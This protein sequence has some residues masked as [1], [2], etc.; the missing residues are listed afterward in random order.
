MNTLVKINQIDQSYGSKRITSLDLRSLQL[1]CVNYFQDHYG[2]SCSC[3]FLTSCFEFEKYPN[4]YTKILIII[5]S[6]G[7]QMTGIIEN[8]YRCVSM[9]FDARFP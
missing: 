7:K 3:W 8:M 1:F 6:V 9:K 2:P 5:L 4:R